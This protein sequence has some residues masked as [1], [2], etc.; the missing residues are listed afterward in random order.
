MNLFLLQLHHELIKLFARKR[1]YL[2]FGA[3]VLVEC[4]VL[5]L[6]HLPKPRAGFRHVI[7]A[8]GFGFERYF[9]GLTLAF[10]VVNLT[11]FLLPG[12]FLALVAGDM[13]S[14]EVEDGTM[15]MMLCRPV[16]RWRIGVLKYL[17]CVV[18]TFALTAFYGLSA[19]AAGTL[20]QGTGGLF[21]AWPPVH[22]FA[23]YDAGPGLGRYLGALPV[24]ALCMTS[25]TSLGFL[26]SCLNMKP[27]AATVVTLSI[28]FFDFI[29]HNVP[30]F[31]SLKGYF[32]TGHMSAW[33][34]VFV[35][36]IDWRGITGDLAYLLA[37]DATFVVV[38]IVAFSQRDFKA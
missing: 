28:L 23:L 19:L 34:G 32:L 9:S 7:E 6:L 21:A 33:L 3:F 5:F 14:K 8:N 1:T 18:Y 20:Y 15:R 24:L 26:C 22:L 11:V 36:R 25:F 29:F 30:Y 10:T 4:A 35:Q 2:G 17:A 38:G 37:L 16:S 31:E 12:L 27:A 13:V